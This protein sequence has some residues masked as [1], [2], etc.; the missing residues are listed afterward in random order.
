MIF[1]FS[2]TAHVSL[3]SVAN[4]N[5]YIVVLGSDDDAMTYDTSVGTTSAHEVFS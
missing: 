5:D 2:I 4:G 3:A 1:F